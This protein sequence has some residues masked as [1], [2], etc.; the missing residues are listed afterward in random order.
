MK[1]RIKGNSLR[2]RL[3]QSEVERLANEGVVESHIDFGGTVL[4]YRIESRGQAN[5]VSARYENDQIV[6]RVPNIEV[7]NW[8][9]TEQTGI[10]S[11]QPVRDGELRILIEKDF[12]CLTPRPSD[13]DA[14]TFNNPKEGRC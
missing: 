9:R 10:R 14:D 1:L 13:E 3:T 8:S 7:A 6:I 12:K 2:L 5:E 4:A 11:S